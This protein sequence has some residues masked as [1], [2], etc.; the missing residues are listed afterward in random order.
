MN[1]ALHDT[2][3]V[4]RRLKESGMENSQ[5]EA[6]AETTHRSIVAATAH[7]A[8]KADL[9]TGLETLESRLTT[10]MAS[11]ETRLTWRL[12]RMML[13]TMLGTMFGVAGLVVAILR[14]I[15]T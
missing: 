9:E 8:T 4:T 2:L 12:F 1:N 11:L 6:V 7:L 5:A 15:P 14:L 10:A 13:G 3:S